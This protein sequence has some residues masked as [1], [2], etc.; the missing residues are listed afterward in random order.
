M[1]EVATDAQR[2][3]LGR[4]PWSVIGPS[5][6]FTVVVAVLALMVGGFLRGAGHT[7]DESGCECP[8]SEAAAGSIDW[9]GTGDT[10]ML[11]STAVEGGRFVI[12]LRYGPDTDA[13]AA[14]RT[15]AA[16]LGDV[17]RPDLE[18]SGVGANRVGQL[19]DPAGRWRLVFQTDRFSGDDFPVTFHV[20]V[21]VRVPDE[22]AETALEELAIAVGRLPS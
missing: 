8:L 20:V 19:E 9:A 11:H 5:F 16:H 15:L 18:T 7:E 21:S 17:Y 12:R 4:G 22:E 1:N 2:K 13:V 10:P 6:G 3:R 14:F